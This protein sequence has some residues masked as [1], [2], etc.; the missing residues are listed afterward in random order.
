[1]TRRIEIKSVL[2]DAA[3]EDFILVIRDQEFRAKSRI[4]AITVMELVAFGDENPSGQMKA[5]LNFL[6]TVIY[7]EDR[8][9]FDDLLHNAEPPIASDEFNEILQGVMQAVSGTPLEQSS[10]SQPQGSNT[11]ERLMGTL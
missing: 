8:E 9:K 6:T 4:P 11:S 1:M 3:D 7:P 5:M 10:S 2:A